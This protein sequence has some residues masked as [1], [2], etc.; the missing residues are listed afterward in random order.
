MKKVYFIGLDIAKNVFQ[1]SM[2]DKTGRQIANRKLS[3]VNV[4]PFFANLEQCVVGLEACGTAHYWAREIGKLGHDVH[5]I[6]PVR[7]KAF[8]GNRNKTDAADARAICEALMH[9]GTCFVSIKTEAQQETDHILAMRERL[10]GNRTQLVNQIRSFLGEHGIIMAQGRRK[11]ETELPGVI[12]KYWDKFG[13]NLQVTLTESFTELQGISE[14]IEH[15]DELIKKQAN[16]EEACKKLMTIKGIGALTAMAL[17]YHIGD[18]SKFKNGRQISAYLGITPKEY[19]SGGKQKLLGITKHG[20]KRVRTL[21]ITA[22]RAAMTGLSRRKKDDEGRPVN[23]DNLEKWILKLK[24]RIGT[25]KT[26]VALANKMA[27]MAWA[28]MVNNEIYN[29][30]KA[31]A[32][33][34]NG[35]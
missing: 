31:S 18:A 30:L 26:A 7:A 13:Y 11:F 16:K 1:L 24:A 21:L 5:L 25:F 4:L 19:S 34:E 10:V 6:Q 22:A 35:N 12:S 27:R 2:A 33:I 32:G 17:V 15:L 9:P 23:L 14:K 28:L 8:L 29:P 3:R 20:A